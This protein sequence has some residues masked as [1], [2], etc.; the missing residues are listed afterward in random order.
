[1]QNTATATNP[2]SLYIL[3]GGA[4]YCGEHLPHTAK[5]T[6]RDI[7]GQPVAEITEAALAELPELLDLECETCG[8]AC[9]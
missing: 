3:E 5:A 9:K 8:R 4:T 2:A 1:L 7:N 6:G